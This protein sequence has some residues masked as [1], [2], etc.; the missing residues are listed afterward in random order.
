MP[1]YE[2]AWTATALRNFDAL[3]EKVAFAIL[4]FCTSTLAQDALRAS[5][6][7]KA[8]F[9]GMRSS[10]RGQYRIIFSVDANDNRVILRSIRHRNV[11]YF[12]N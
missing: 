4:E 6:P 8:P 3:P 1:D 10:R 7:L 9:E 2:V 5:K 12:K 11:A